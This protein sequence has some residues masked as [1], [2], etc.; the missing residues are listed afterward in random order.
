ME[1]N[2]RKQKRKEL[3]SK[4]K[5]KYRL[6]I[7]NDETFEEKASLK[8]SPLNVF[9]VVGSLALFLITSTIYIIAFTPLR[10]YIP[11]YADVGMRR[12]LLNL[13]LKADSLEKESQLKET[14]ILNIK[15]VINGNIN[16]DKSANPKDTTNKYVNIS[17]KPSEQDLAFR[18]EI[19]D[20]EKSYSLKVNENSNNR[21]DISSFFFF[22]PIKGM[23]TASFNERENHYGVD[24]AA[25]KDEAVKVVLDGTVIFSQWS[26]KTGHTL[27]IQHSNNL[28]SVYKHNSALLKKEG[29][30]VSAGDPVAIVG[31][32]GELTSGPHLHFELWYNGAPVNPQDYINF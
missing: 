20:Q 13:T 3:V 31:N 8:L 10:E 16:A 32:S 14:Y 25:Q 7:L 26:A 12:N 15:N 21:N 1:E 4:L 30:R 28:I 19:E 6:V 9:I 2:T 22:V 29:D 5:L 23:V 18:E 17:S 24:V 11:G 27:Q